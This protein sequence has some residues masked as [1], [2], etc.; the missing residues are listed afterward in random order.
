MS[1]VPAQSILAPAPGSA[2]EAIGE[3]AA[4]LHAGGAAIFAIVVALAVYAVLAPAREIHAKGWIL[5][6]GL[7]IPAAILAALFTYAFGLGGGLRAIEGPPP[8]R[9]HVTGRQWWWEVRYEDRSRA[10]AAIPLAN[11]IHVPAGRPVELVLDTADVI[12]AFWVPALAGKADMVPGRVNRLMLEAK[13]P[14]IFRGQ[15]AEYCGAQHAL[16]AFE[17]VVESEQ[18]FRAW[19]ERQA[20][21]AASRDDASWARGLEL[22]FRGGCAACHTIRGTRAAG[23]LG[24]D[25]THVGSRRTLAAGLL[26]NHAGTMGGWIAGAQELKPGNAM[27]STRAFSGPE[28]RALS[29]WL[30][31]L[32]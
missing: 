26:R 10:G 1:G 12:H 31:D 3:L 18:Q 14:G 13:Q 29:A 8:Q 7:A 19:L 4:I 16:M 15:C 6:G 20:A 28:L 25:L 17:V 24:P 22:F 5:L 11:E 32:E 9:I 2:A 21:P 27:P 23:K 30:E